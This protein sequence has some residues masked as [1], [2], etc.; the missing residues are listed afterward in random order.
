MPGGKCRCDCT[1]KSLVAGGWLIDWL[2]IFIWAGSYRLIPWGQAS[3][4]RASLRVF[5]LTYST[6][7]TTTHGPHVQRTLAGPGR[8]WHS[9]WRIAL[10]IDSVPS[11]FPPEPVIDDG[12]SRRGWVFA[13][14]LHNLSLSGGLD[15]LPSTTP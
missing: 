4:V 7:L 12:P 8:Y 14:G 3:R 10:V 13:T 2:G 15:I 1:V 9:S 5:Y 11:S 6:L